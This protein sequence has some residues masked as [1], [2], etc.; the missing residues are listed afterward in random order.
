MSSDESDAHVPIKSLRG[1]ATEV[2]VGHLE[3]LWKNWK[4]LTGWEPTRGVL[5][6]LA[7]DACYLLAIDQEAEEVC[8][9]K[10]TFEALTEWEAKTGDTVVRPILL[11]ANHARQIPVALHYWADPADGEWDDDVVAIV[12]ELP[13]GT[14]RA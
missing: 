12:L 2:K 8:F 7:P 13:H 1:Q 3:R 5:D 14:A 9:G 10:M 11:K 4:A 6:D